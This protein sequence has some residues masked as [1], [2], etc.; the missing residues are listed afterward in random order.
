M[1]GNMNEKDHE[2][3]YEEPWSTTDTECVQDAN[4]VKATRLKNEELSRGRRQ[5]KSNL[6]KSLANKK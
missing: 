2:L 5:I 3:P 6:E 4:T 1:D